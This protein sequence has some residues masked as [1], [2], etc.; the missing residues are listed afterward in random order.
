MQKKPARII[1]GTGRDNR[2][3]TFY[4]TPMPE[5][6]LNIFLKRLS[7]LLY[8]SEKDKPNKGEQ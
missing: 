8:E 5:A 3:Y 1:K 2:T 4:F 6:Q 7:E